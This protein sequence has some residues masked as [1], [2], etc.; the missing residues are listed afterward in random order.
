MR[1]LSLISKIDFLGN[2]VNF[3]INK[4][5]KFKTVFGG[6]ISF[7]IYIL[8]IYLFVIIGKDFLLKQNP[9]GNLE[10]RTRASLKKN[11]TEFD[12]IGGFRL[13]H[14]SFDSIDMNRYFYPYFTFSETNFNE[15]KE[16]TYKNTI[17]PAISCDKIPK[18]DEIDTRDLNL[19][20]YI[21]P[22]L[23]NFTDKDLGGS[24]SYRENSTQINFFLSICDYEKKNCKDPIKFKN[25]T[26]DQIILLEIIRSE[27]TYSI[28]N[29]KNP[30]KTSL[31]SE[32]NT[33][34][35]RRLAYNSLFLSEYELEDDV[36][37]FFEYTKNK[38][39]IGISDNIIF[40]DCKEEPDISKPKNLTSKQLFY[41]IGYFT[42]SKNINFF[43]RSYVKFPE[44]Y[45]NA[46]ALM[47]LYIIIISLIYSIYN[48]FRLDIYLCNRLIFIEDDKGID[49]KGKKLNYSDKERL[50]IQQDIKKYLDLQ[51][52]K[53]NTI[54]EIINN[55]YQTNNSIKQES[56]KSIQIEKKN[57]EISIN[58]SHRN[59]NLTNYDN[60]LMDKLLLE[61][62]QNEK[63]EKLKSY[64]EMTFNKFKETKNKINFSFFNL[65]ISKLSRNRK[66]KSISKLYEI[67]SEK[68]DEKFDIFYYMKLDRKIDL[69]QQI[70]F[71]KNE[72]EIID[73]ISN[74]NFKVSMNYLKD[75]KIE[76][77]EL[78]IQ[79]LMKRKLNKDSKEKKIND[80][81]IF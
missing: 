52:D 50:I 47:D 14:I 26:K 78:I 2:S 69:N 25:E 22:D 37:N 59:F 17:I 42:F 58:N 30:F 1:L 44:V 3:T 63:E 29:F 31:K 40:D 13:T 10:S 49:F 5:D 7:F 36:G 72:T 57:R 60:N 24:T 81:F 77:D 62:N 80:L 79:N 12:F 20:L 68:F 65:F 27:V 39:A 15:K 9:N 38:K 71:N 46:S 61:K 11:I 21:C 53:N 64:L 4:N 41:Y 28:N 43:T 23:R 45:A 67:Y 56:K 32:V 74:K 8:Y 54:S 73:I 35:Y 70:L 76:N 48:K 6:L 18:L 19:S 66:K 75:V 33:I 34:N 55:F 51:I 16:S